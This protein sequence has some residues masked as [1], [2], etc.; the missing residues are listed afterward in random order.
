MKKSVYDPNNVG[1]N[2]YDYD[3]FI[4]TPE[5]PTKTSDLVN[6]VPFLTQHQDITG[7]ADKTY[8]DTELNKKADTTYVNTELNKKSDKSY[9]DTELDKKADITDVPT[10][11]SDLTN[12][13]PFLTEHQSLSDY[14]T[15]TEVNQLI[16][17]LNNK[18][19]VNSDK[20]IIQTG[21]TSNITVQVKEHG[22]PAP[23]KTVNIYEKEE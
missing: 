18:M 13:V 4:H 11:T 9:V 10:K 20:T 12:D 22:F 17:D 15:K 6:D 2:V 7:K 3:N 23:N 1:K 5:I 21:E 19:N 14:Y 16:K 8:V